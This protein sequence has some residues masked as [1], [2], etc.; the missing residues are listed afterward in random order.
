MITRILR[1]MVLLAIIASP[2][3]T[4]GADKETIFINL[5]TNDPNKVLM[6]L[7]AS[8]QYAKNG[9]PV[10]IFLN[11]NAVILGVVNKSGNSSKAQEALKIAV[12]NGALVNICPTCLAKLGLSSFDLIEGI[13]LG[14]PHK[15]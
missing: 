15:S 7:D 14:S 5:A 12:T 11:D 8:R 9:F 13:T 10:V 6:A 4:L 1:A 3:T 2:L